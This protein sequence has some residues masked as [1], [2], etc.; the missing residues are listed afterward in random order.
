LGGGVYSNI[1]IAGP[2]E[3]AFNADLADLSPDDIYAA[4][5]GWQAEHDD[6]REFDVADLDE[7]QRV[8]V[9]R[10]QRRLHDAGMVQIVPH[11][12]AS[13]FGERVLIASALREDWPGIGIAASGGET[14]WVP[15][16]A[17]SRPLGPREAYCIFKGR[18]LLRTFNP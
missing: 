11:T 10:L 12:L 6:L 17:T 8:E 4:F 15:C 5:A 1:A 18:R 14:T 13:F 2:L 16:G 7:G 9:A 3:H